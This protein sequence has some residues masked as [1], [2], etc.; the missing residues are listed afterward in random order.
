MNTLR[1]TTLLWAALLLAACSPN[2]KN[3]EPRQDEAAPS[4]AQLRQSYQ[5]TLSQH[6]SC[7]VDQDCQALAGPCAL[8]LGECYEV[9]NQSLD[10]QE[11]VSQA[12]AFER[13]G[14]QGAACQCQ[15]AA[16]SV[17]CAS[18]QCISEDLCDG[19]QPGDIWL[20]EDRC[21][22]CACTPQG[23]RCNDA[24][25]QDPCEGVELPTCPMACPQRDPQGA[26]CQPWEE[27][28]GDPEGLRCTCQEG[29]WACQT[30]SPQHEAC[31]ATCRP[32]P[33]LDCPQQAQRYQA[34][35]EG[36]RGCQQDADC[37]TLAGPCSIGLGACYA[38]V[39]RDLLQGQLQALGMEWLESQCRG[40]AC[41][42]CGAPPPSVCAQGQCQEGQFC[43]GH[44][45]GQQWE[46]EDGCNTCLCTVDGPLC[47]QDPCGPPDLGHD[48]DTDAPAPEDM[49][50]DA[51]L[52]EDMPPG[53]SGPDAE[54]DV[55]P[56]Q[57]DAPD[58]DEDPCPQIQSD[59][60]ALLE[61]AS[62]CQVDAD[63]GW[64]YGQC[65][66][67][68]G[69]CYEAVNQS[70]RQQDLGALGARWFQNRCG[71]E[72]CRCDTPPPIA[73]QEGRCVLGQACGDHQQG[74]IWTQ[75]DGCTQCACTAGGEVCDSSACP[76]V[77]QEI[78][79]QY[80]GLVEDARG[81]QQDSD[82]QILDGHCGVGECYAYVN[83]SL[84]QETLDALHER[85]RQEE[86][87]DIFCHCT[88][89]YEVSCQEGQCK[90]TV[91][92]E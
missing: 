13:A 60:D 34:L 65:G 44:A 25:C 75:E 81:C 66:L 76:T 10:R 69:S 84:Q 21:T 87:V 92:E 3:G 27:S 56:D 71:G 40:E 73:C 61:Q 91:I 46:A 77:C 15:G 41:Q 24:G 39:N 59:Y 82:C 1:L 2:N 62:G 14:C 48:A 79:S 4:C 17:R 37:Q 53:D 30:L 29:A 47:T 80:A 72:P 12:L 86:C 38:F 43:P 16:P 19:H 7:Q 90:A 8:G 83:M 33:P 74:D 45:L 54:L 85:Y 11:L 68:L 20:A 9:G 32:A 18:G 51:D 89:A 67:G 35:L 5:D 42:G 28:C 78:E 23:K 6:Q 49:P 57:P 63:C 22:T 58:Q 55:A 50:G 26:A 52:V 31:L 70:L 88:L 64:L 36:A